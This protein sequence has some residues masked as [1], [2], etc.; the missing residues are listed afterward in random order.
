MTHSILMISAEYPPMPTVGGLRVAKLARALIDAGWRV[1][2]VTVDQASWAP[3]SPAPSPFDSGAQVH[4]VPNPDPYTR[5]VNL[6]RALAPPSAPAPAAARAPE[7]PATRTGGAQ[8]LARRMAFAAIRGAWVPDA[9]AG[10]VR[11]AVRRALALIR[12]RRPDAIFSSFP[13]ASSHL[14]ALRVAKRTGIPWVADFRDAYTGASYRHE[15][16]LNRWAA[17]RLE[18]AILAR[19]DLVTTVNGAI[20]DLLRHEGAPPRKLVLPQGAQ[21]AWLDQGLPAMPPPGAPKLQLLH[22]GVISRAFSDPTVVL[23]ALAKLDPEERAQIELVFLGEQL[24][25]D[26]DRMASSLGVGANVRTLAFRPRLAAMEIARQAHGFLLLRTHRG[27]DFTPGKMW[28]YFALARPVLGVIDPESDAADI[29][30]RSRMGDVVPFY[31][32]SALAMALRSWVVRWRSGLLRLQ[33]DIDVL[34]T[35]D[36]RTL[37]ARLAGALRAL[38]RRSARP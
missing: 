25:V 11:P 26:I 1:D 21:L 2:V 12:E 8:G 20:G 19:A 14:A 23:E 13:P 6:R 32:V 16:G 7:A 30:R 3:R 24:D 29:L 9:F 5:L 4:E 35:Y 38:P 15:V 18:R 37:A 34:A 10:W 17:P 31:D 28:D 33:P 27:K 36:T 22:L